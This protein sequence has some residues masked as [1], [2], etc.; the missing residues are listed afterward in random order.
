MSESPEEPERVAQP[1]PTENKTVKVVKVPGS[2]RAQRPLPAG[3]DPHPHD[4]LLTARASEDRP[5]VWGEKPSAGR[6]K[7][8]R[9][10]KGENDDRLQQD[11]PPHWG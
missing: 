6:K 1:D 10:T 5:E 3:A 7:A 8:S 9:N 2:R 11:R 4:H